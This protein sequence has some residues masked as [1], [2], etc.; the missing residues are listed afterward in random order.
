MKFTSRQS[1]PFPGSTPLHASRPHVLI[2]SEGA[3]WPADQ[4]YRVHGAQIARALRGSGLS[5][6]V[7][8]LQAPPADAPRWLREMHLDWPAATSEAASLFRRGWAGP[9][10]PLRDR[11]ARYHGATPERLGGLVPLVRHHRPRV[12]LALGQRGPVMLTGIREAAGDALRLWYAADEPCYFHLSCLPR[13]AADRWPRRLRAALMSLGLERSFAAGVDGAI[14]VSSLDTRLLRTLGGA[15]AATTIRN[16]VD[17]GTWR[18]APTRAEPDSLIFW[19]RMDFEPNID[20]VTWFA[21]TVWP[22]LRQRHPRATWRIVG[23]RP[24]PAVRELGAIP[25]IDVTGEVDD[26]RPYARRAAAV[27]LPMRCGGGIKNKLLEAAALARPIV[28]SP[29]TIRDL[30]L[31]QPRPIAVCRSPESWADA[32]ERIWQQPDH[33]AKLGQAARQW[34]KTHHTWSGAADRLLA[35]A[36]SLMPLRARLQP[37][38]RKPLDCGLDEAA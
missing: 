12:V 35:F 8:S 25:G 11:I 36:A 14:G 5:V 3:L 2:V 1:V 15:P 20:A 30:T 27:V 17:L 10:R 21:H 29:R 9:A 16:G 24:A 26:I 28:A 6:A 38:S 37:V 13:E 22:T 31:P 23:K 34:V 32:I 7:T 19:G 4:G 33:A 18:P